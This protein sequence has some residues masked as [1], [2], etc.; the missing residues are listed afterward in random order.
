MAHEILLQAKNI[1]KSF[2]QIEALN[3]LNLELKKGEILG[4]LGENGAGKSTT[5]SIL[6]G[7]LQYD[8]GD[9]L[10]KGK[11]LKTCKKQ[12]QSRLGYVPQEIALFHDLNCLDNLKFWAKI[13][14]IDKNQINDK[15]HE[16]AELFE[17]TNVLKRKPDT[18]SGGYKRRLNIACAVLHEPEILFL[19]EPTVGIDVSI[20]K[21]ILQTVRK[22]ANDGMAILYT[23]HYI[24]ELEEISD[25]VLM[26]KEG[27]EIATLSREDFKDKS[28]EEIYLES[29]S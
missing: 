18:L 29:I 7:E 23:S 10:Y 13:Y 1:R 8:S 4:F 2:G 22:F 6:S 9:V 14:Q 16:I 27:K 19:D 15:I 20:R 3:D 25:N 24:D 5:I 21:S 28:L 17:I 11:N 26:V 12:F